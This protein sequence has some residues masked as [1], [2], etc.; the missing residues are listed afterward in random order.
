MRREEICA[1][2]PHSGSMCLLER[3]DAWDASSID[4]SATSHRDAANPL[5]SLDH[6]PAVC[7]VEY[8]AQA[9]AVHGS[10]IEPAHGDGASAGFLASVRDLKLAA[11]RLDTVAGDLHIHADRVSGGDNSFIYEFAV[12]D[13]DVTLVSGRVAVMLMGPAA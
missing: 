11:D 3:V 9:M 1:R 5:R 13:G 2:I 12:R 7:A 6:L 4:C 10:L 8:A